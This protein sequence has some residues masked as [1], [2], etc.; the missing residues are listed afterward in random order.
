MTDEVFEALAALEF[1]AAEV[2]AAATVLASGR[3]DHQPPKTSKCIGAYTLDRLFFNPG[4]IYQWFVTQMYA[5]FS[6][7]A[8]QP[9][10]DRGFG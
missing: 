9:C 1:A 7:E 2:E 3:L 8:G 6:V 4:R 10:S 5:R